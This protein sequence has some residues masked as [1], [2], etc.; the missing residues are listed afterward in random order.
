MRPLLFLTLL[1]LAACGDPVVSNPTDVSPKVDMSADQTV[2]P[3]IPKMACEPLQDAFK[4]SVRA[5][6]RS[7][8]ENSDCQLAE[9]AGPCDCAIGVGPGEEAQEAFDQKLQIFGDKR[10]LLDENQCRNPFACAG[11]TCP[12]YN[13]LS[14]PG[15]LVPRCRGGEC[16]VAQLPSCA[17]YEAKKTGGLIS[18]SECV[19]KA[20]CMLRTDLNPCDCPEPV[21]G[22]FPALTAGVIREIIDINNARCGTTC[23]GC[24]QIQE[25]D[26]IDKVC[27]L[28]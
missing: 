11:D 28:K 24:P 7:C 17:D 13:V 1:S 20:D 9:R 19:T 4:A 25:L 3:D 26:C 8:F 5:L 22:S 16:E 27:V 2:T 21:N 18:K 6:G 23:T 12:N 14:N 10:I 15:E